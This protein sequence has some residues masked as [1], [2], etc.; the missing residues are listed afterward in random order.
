M[1]KD[2]HN[3]L[4]SVIKETHK[5]RNSLVDDKK[6][7]KGEVESIN[8]QLDLYKNQINLLQNELKL[9]DEKVDSYKVKEGQN[10]EEYKKY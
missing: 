9:S 10:D 4:L 8:S 1:L 6:I 3:E 7:L 5:E 2:T